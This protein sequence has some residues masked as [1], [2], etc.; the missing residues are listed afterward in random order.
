MKQK[1][2]VKSLIPQKE[3]FNWG[4]LTALLFVLWV[5]LCLWA[6]S[7]M[8]TSSVWAAKLWRDISTLSY[9]GVDDVVE[10]LYNLD[11][12]KP[13]DL[14]KKVAKMYINNNKDFYLQTSIPLVVNAEDTIGD[15]LKENQVIAWEKSNILW[16]YGNRVRGSNVTI[17]WWN[18]NVM[19]SIDGWSFDNSV[20]FWWENIKLRDGNGFPAIIVWW[21][22]HQVEPGHNW[23]AIVWW[24]TQQINDK[25]AKNVVLIWWTEI[26]VNGENAENIVVWWKNIDVNEWINNVFVFSSDWSFVPQS[27][28]AFY[29]NVAKGLWI[30]TQALGKWVTTNG[31]VKIGE[32]DINT[33]CS[34]SNLGV[35]GAWK[36]DS[37]ISCL[38]WCSKTSAWEVWGPWE[39]LDR[40]KD[41]EIACDNN[42][43]RCSQKHVDIPEV[44]S[45][46]GFCVK[47]GWMSLD[48]SSPCTP[49]EWGNYENAFFEAGLIDSTVDCPFGAA[50]KC[51]Y[52]CNTGYHLTWDRTNIYNSYRNKNQ[53][54]F[55]DCNLVEQLWSEW[56]DGD[57][58]PI[59]LKHNQM[60]TGYN[61][62]IAVCART[63]PY[64]WTDRWTKGDAFP[65]HCGNNQHKKPLVCVNGEMRLAN[66]YTSPWATSTNAKS[67]GYWH[68]YC[69]TAPFACDT[70]AEKFD[71]SRTDI[72][73]TLDD[74]VS[75]WQ[76]TDRSTSN[77]TRGKYK[78]CLD[79]KTWANYTTAPGNEAAWCVIVQSQPYQVHYKFEWCQSGYHRSNREWE[80]DKYICRKECKVDWA[81]TS[82]TVRDN[83][84]I[85]L[86]KDTS[87]ECSKDNWYDVCL[88]KTFT[89]NDGV[90]DSVDTSYKY[91][92]CKQNWRDCQWEWYNVEASVATSNMTYSKYEWACHSWKAY[93]TNTNWTYNTRWSD[94]G[95]PKNNYVNIQKPCSDGGEFYKLIG[96]ANCHHTTNNKYCESEENAVKISDCTSSEAGKVVAGWKYKQWTSATYN[97]G[98]M[99]NYWTCEFY[100][101]DWY[102]RNGSS[103][104]KNPTMTCDSAFTA[105]TWFVVLADETK[106]E[107]H[108]YWYRHVWR[109]TTGSNS[110][111]YKYS[112]WCFDDC[113]TFYHRV[114]DEC[115]LI[116]KDY[117][118]FGTVPAHASVRKDSHV[119][120]Y[121]PK[122]YRYSNS[123]EECG[124]YC[125]DGYTWNGY[126]CVNK[127]WK[128]DICSNTISY[129]ADWW[130][131]NG[132]KSEDEVLCNEWVS[133]PWATKKCYKFEW[134][135]QSNT[136]VGWEWS[137][138]TPTTNMSLVAHWSRDTSADG[139][140]YK[141]GWDTPELD[142]SNMEWNG[143]A[144]GDD[145]TWSYVNDT[146]KTLTA[147]QWRCKTSL[148]YVHDWN[149]CRQ[150]RCATPI[151]NGQ[152]IK[153]WDKETLLTSVSDG[154]AWSYTS[155]SNPWA[156]QWTCQDG[157]T[158]AKDAAGNWLNYCEAKKC[159]WT[160]W[161]GPKVITWV[162]EYTW[163]VTK[164]WHSV[165]GT[166]AP[167]V[168]E[169][170]CQAWW[171]PSWNT[172]ILD[173]NAQCKNSENP[174]ANGQT[175]WCIS[176]T[177]V[178]LNTTTYTNKNTWSCKSKTNDTKTEWCRHCKS[179][180]TWD[181]CV[182]MENWQCNNNEKYRCFT[183]EAINTGT[184][185]ANHKWTWD[186]DWVNG[187]NK[188]TWC[189]K[190][191]DGYIYNT[192]TKKCEPAKD[193]DCGKN[194]K[195]YNCAEWTSWSTA[196][197]DHQYTWDCVWSL[198]TEHCMECEDGY[199]VVKDESWKLF[200]AKCDPNYT[201]EERDGYVI[202]TIMAECEEWY[203]WSSDKKKCLRIANCLSEWGDIENYIPYDSYW[204]YSPWNA[205]PYNWNESK[206][207]D[208]IRPLW[209]D[210]TWKCYDS[211]TSHKVNQ[212]AV[213]EFV[214]PSW[215]DCYNWVSGVS[216]LKHECYF[217]PP[218]WD[219]MPSDYFY[220]N[221]ERAAQ[222]WTYIS[223]YS[224]FKSKKDNHEKWCFFYCPSQYYVDGRCY[225]FVCKFNTIP[226]HW[227]TEMILEPA[228]SS[229][230]SFNKVSYATLQSYKESGKSWCYVACKP[231]YR[232]K[233][234]NW[235]T[236]CRKQCDKEKEHFS[237][238][239]VVGWCYSCGRD[240]IPWSWDN[241]F[242]NNMAC[243]KA[244]TTSFC[245][246]NECW[247]SDIRE[248]C[249]LNSTPLTCPD[250][251][252]HMDADGKCW[253]CLP[254]TTWNG[255]QCA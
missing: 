192:T 159:G 236:Y 52:K 208:A 238:S 69:Q 58:K 235:K 13:E 164:N 127:S 9:S 251:T 162:W 65:E 191:V 3:N 165:T 55:K 115:E 63:N 137:R 177:V 117:G 67:A 16:W 43:S 228:N 167:W 39:M 112:D 241:Q 172:C 125:D 99:R 169:W 105:S 122:E 155:S 87:K 123:Y 51:V 83:R 198:S 143:D 242:E 205:S 103:C 100:C 6:A 91:S 138:I 101:N 139:C 30:N 61:T 89:C 158:R 84:T 33:V 76:T 129:D 204:N 250:A 220:G 224:E 37:K 27:S 92:R 221:A 128:C 237:T 141:C 108:A 212:W 68:R 15:S 174:T 109:Y 151:P 184:D 42:P 163:T 90:W 71:L 202:C 154:K 132:L 32:V 29:L 50:N 217:N 215:Y 153:L 14:E 28:W 1:R 188:A 178:D 189:F 170:T 73:T 111:D 113:H 144:D 78:L 116:T 60:V 213:C 245:G 196:F 179:W 173:E 94:N 175:T 152:N 193:W 54:C 70:S 134:W 190:C 140:A 171:V 26:D 124:F 38:V 64:D 211:S 79:Y 218:R 34:T 10:V 5:A 149:E 25:G 180:Y 219:D 49:D 47:P 56:I 53:K 199:E 119:G 187:W 200:C 147:C 185:N 118:C 216:C 247:W 233:T 24:E 239:D 106:S 146:T 194:P 88:E 246:G 249:L 230:T 45:Y 17:I 160:P 20:I 97:W 183:W 234:I 226:L 157:Y 81:D 74:N 166:T 227:W 203:K 96:C 207:F 114:D 195:H 7:L 120:S 75:S 133:L 62:D 168:C 4:F 102:Y 161:T 229:E 136:R 225:D 40:G 35:I 130:I 11:F 253:K 131:V 248:W 98:T 66:N 46:T 8:S 126:A 197:K 135:Y 36:V 59:I 82:Y 2:K 22:N 41:C 243:V 107:D 86:Y 18:E 142:S 231:D 104:K 110:G 252:W 223:S 19:E 244:C 209:D 85:T 214:C 145:K 44:A 80:T 240:E 23:I 156:C 121:G 21:K 201:R 31:P 150:R 72:T 232:E 186:C 181:N 93:G 48:N 148:W 255:T 222:S 95:Y 210:V 57:W 182:K 77:W 254:G 206:I 176:G 12:A